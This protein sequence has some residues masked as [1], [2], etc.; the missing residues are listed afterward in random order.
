MSFWDDGRRRNTGFLL[1][2]VLCNVGWF[3]NVL[4]AAHKHPLWGPAAQVALVFLHVFLVCPLYELDWRGE[5]VL[6]LA[7]V[8]SMKSVNSRLRVLTLDSCFSRCSMLQWLSPFSGT[9]SP[10]SRGRCVLV[11]HPDIRV[12]FGSC[13]ELN[14]LLVNWIWQTIHAF[15]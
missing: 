10:L 11:A 6:I 1:N 14:M 13:Q 9:S 7:S 8:W 15:H 12:A 3:A 5:V 2:S 4:L